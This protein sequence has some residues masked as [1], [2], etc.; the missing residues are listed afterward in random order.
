MADRPIHHVTPLAAIAG[1]RR[2]RRHLQVMA[3]GVSAGLILI[4]LGLWDV[5]EP[6]FWVGLAL[7]AMTL[8]GIQFHCTRVKCRILG[9]SRRSWE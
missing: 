2:H 9:R 8:Y 7:A 3:A 1:Q 6:L 5:I 4:I